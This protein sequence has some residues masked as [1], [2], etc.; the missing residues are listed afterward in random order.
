M[1]TRTLLKGLGQSVG[2]ELLELDD[3]LLELA[4]ASG[5]DYGTVEAAL[6]EH[7]PLGAGQPGLLQEVRTHAW[8]YMFEG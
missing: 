3:E 2:S 4:C 5:T 7:D 1:G 6:Q 8:L